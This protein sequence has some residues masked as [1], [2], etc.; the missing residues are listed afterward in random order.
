MSDSKESTY[1]FNGQLDRWPAFEKMMKAK[2]L[3][4]KGYNIIWNDN[5]VHEEIPVLPPVPPED[6]SQRVYDMW[7][8]E[9]DST[10][11]KIKEYLTVAD[12]ST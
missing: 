1:K 11:K 4:V 6:C 5:G 9:K 8:M 12:S 10:E 3:G 7:K 2:A